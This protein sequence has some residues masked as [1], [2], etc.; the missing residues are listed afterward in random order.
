MHCCKMETTVNENSERRSE[1]ERKPPAGGIKNVQGFKR[2]HPYLESRNA[3]T[4]E[5]RDKN[6]CVWLR[7]LNIQEWCT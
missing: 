4:S 3:T 5:T 1:S 6:N 2:G 7:R